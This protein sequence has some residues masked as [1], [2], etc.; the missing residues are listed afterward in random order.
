MAIS[1]ARA[2]WYRATERPRLAAARY[3]NGDGSVWRHQAFPLIS[4]YTATFNRVDLLMSRA[5]PS[6]LNQEYQNW[7]WIVAAH[8]CTDGTQDAVRSLND[9]R[10]RVIDVPRRRTYPPTAENHWLAGPV[11]PAN[12]ALR[13]VRGAWFARIDDDDIW[14]PRNLRALLRF[15][16]KGNFEFV[17]AQ[18]AGPDG[19][20]KPYTIDGVTVGAIQTWLCR[21][22]LRLFK[23]N[24]DCWRKSWDRVSDTDVQRRMVNAGVR[25][26][27]LPLTTACVIPR[28]GES[29]IGSRVYL[30]DPE[31]TEK[32]FAF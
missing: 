15:A 29:Q 24:P 17:S 16:Q 31:A 25:M 10:I 30:A 2:G 14:L 19:V 7:E 23:F 18:L 22:Y 4:V 5:A 26:G 3:D 28:P 13:A 11:A 12:A 9:P 27:Y 21:S 32:R 8:G 1:A 6:V 20:V